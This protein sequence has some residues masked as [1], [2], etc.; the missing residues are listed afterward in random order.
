MTLSWFAMSAPNCYGS[1]RVSGKMEGGIRKDEHLPGS[2]FLGPPWCSPSHIPPPSMENFTHIPI[3]R[4]GV[5]MSRSL[6]LGVVGVVIITP[7]LLPSLFTMLAFGVQI[8]II[9]SQSGM[10]TVGIV[11]GSGVVDRW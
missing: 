8:V 7:V 5:L 9:G 3:Q 10:Q 2:H 6:W 4:G 1:G 11:D